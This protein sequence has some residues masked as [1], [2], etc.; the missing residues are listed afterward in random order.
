MIVIGLVFLVI[1]ILIEACM[2]VNP[3]LRSGT[4]TRIGLHFIMI[5]LF[6]IVVWTAG[7]FW[8]FLYINGPLISGISVFVFTVLFLLELNKPYVRYKDNQ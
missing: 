2:R 7:N 6:N 4:S 3:E 1:G 5:G 8:F